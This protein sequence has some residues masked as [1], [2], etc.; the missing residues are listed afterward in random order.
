MH[1]YSGNVFMGLNVH[2]PLP[3]LPHVAQSVPCPCPLVV[4]Q[5]K[6]CCSEFPL[7]GQEEEGCCLAF[8]FKVDFYGLTENTLLMPTHTWSLSLLGPLQLPRA[9]ALQAPLDGPSPWC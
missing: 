6:C 1:V 3:S 5:S 9:Q 2:F 4:S 7:W 8:T